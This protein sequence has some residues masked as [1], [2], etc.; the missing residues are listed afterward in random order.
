MATDPLYQHQQ[1][2][3]APSHFDP[4]VMDGKHFHHQQQQQ[5]HHQPQHQ[6]PHHPHSHYHQ[7]SPVTHTQDQIGW[8]FVE[9]YYTTLSR[10]PERLHLYY[11]KPSQFCFGNEAE[12]VT[13]AVGLSEIQ[14]RIRS[15]DFRSC[16][17][18]V[19]NVDA[20]GSFDNILVIV[21]GEISNDGQPS[22]KFVQ[23]FVLAQQPNGYFVLNDVFRYLK[24][25]EEEEVDVAAAPVAVP[26][27]QNEA[28]TAEKPVEEQQTPAPVAPVEKVE[29]KKEEKEEVKETEAEEK[30]NAEH[31]NAEQKAAEPQAE[32]LTTSGATEAVDE[33]LAE[34]EKKE[35][36]NVAED[37]QPKEEAAAAVPA[38]EDKK[39]DS[40]EKPVETENKE[41]PKEQEEE[42]SSPGIKEPEHTPAA[43]DTAPTEAAP[44]PA[45]APAQSAKQ[46]EKPAAPVPKVP[47]S[48]ANIASKNKA[49]SAA[50]PAV[51]IVPVKAPSAPTAEKKE[52]T[53]TPAAT[54]AKKDE[55]KEKPAANGAA[56]PA[57]PAPSTASGEWQTVAGNEHHVRRQSTRGGGAGGLGRGGAAA[58]EASSAAP[59]NVTDSENNTFA[60][61]KNVN[62]K[63]DAALLK[64][65]LSKYGPIKDFDVSR[66][67]NCAFV[68]FGTPAAYRAAVAANPHTIGSEQI[69]VESRRFRNTAG[70][71]SNGRPRGDRGSGGRGGMKNF[72]RSGRSG[73]GPK[74]TTA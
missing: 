33:K 37:E 48:W 20:Q 66:P 62:E 31:I 15:L 59:H 70:P 3:P 27:Q 4:A 34:E 68:E 57:A 74:R 38:A 25:E 42:Q 10:E 54:P 64:A 39:E 21:I 71:G 51:P 18:R 49:A 26:E 45:A 19:L 24:D 69:T 11:N 28:V 41:A 56:K 43:V 29:E 73:Q 35:E 14:S 13:V 32:D 22:R 50:V 58:G 63:V 72:P 44:A 65:T 6:Q 67:K 12:K 23:T 55:K 2:F 47:M 60:Y 1:Q 61:I 9:Q 36:K 30:K 46:Q 5:H 52:E 7:E 40:E 16:K 17:V 8:Y 53:A